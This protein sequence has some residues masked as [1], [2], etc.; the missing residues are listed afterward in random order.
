MSVDRGT[1]GTSRV[2]RLVANDRVSTPAVRLTPVAFEALPASPLEGMQA[3]VNDSNT[4]TWG[5]T[6]AGGGANKILAV[7]NGANWTCAGK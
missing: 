1:K 3:W 2:G 5:A 4:A 7:Y 6:V